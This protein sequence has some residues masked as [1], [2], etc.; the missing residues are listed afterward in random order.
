MAGPPRGPRRPRGRARRLRSAALLAGAALLAAAAVSARAAAARSDGVNPAPV[1]LVR[2]PARPLSEMAR[3]GRDLFFDP[4]LSANGRQAC[5]T[6]HSPAHAYGPPDG[7]SVQPGGPSGRLEGDRAAPSL[8]YVDRIP[9]FTIGPDKG[10]ADLPAAGT[11]TAASALA[12]AAGGTRPSKVAGS[13]AAATASAAAM[14]PQG[15]LFWDGRAPTLQAQA[16]AP[17]FNPVEMANRDT[18]AVAGRLRAAYGAR[19]ARLVGPQAVANSR[20]LVYEATYAVVRFEVEDASFHP[21]S[22]KYDA[23]LE[24]RA[25]LTREEAR[26]LRLF[27]DP[28]R[29][30]CAGC[31]LDR[32]GPDGV[33]PAF[34]DYQYEALGVPRNRALPAAHDGAAYDR[35][36]C[37]PQRTDLAAATRYCGM[38]RTPSLRNVA[39]RRVFFHNGVY[40][41]LA[42]VLDFYALRDVQPAAIYPRAADGRVARFD[43]LPPADRANVDETDPPF[44]RAAGA[45]PALSEQDRRDLIAFLRTLT[46]GWR[47]G[48]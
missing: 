16:M 20:Q 27:E 24:G 13:A 36:L 23:W 10:A 25:R 19:L 31:H 45:P 41:S 32:P 3:I 5:A 22:S 38:F 17:L 14:V 2:P 48:R 11:P 44:G 21:Y 29:G 30:N 26:G 33:P 4:R 47:P 15:G 7:R 46:D 28:A 37:G 8:R 1:R 43:D 42:E 40:H 12:G 39:T 6:C 9:P 35:G 18:D 34:T